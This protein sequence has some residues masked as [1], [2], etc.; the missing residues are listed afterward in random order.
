[1]SVALYRKISNWASLSPNRVR[2]FFLECAPLSYRTLKK[3]GKPAWAV[4]NGYGFRSWCVSTY[5]NKGDLAMRRDLCCRYV[6]F[7]QPKPT[8]VDIR[9]YVNG[10]DPKNEIFSRPIYACQG[11]FFR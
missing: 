5:L 6:R 10:V 7:G 8:Y 11:W 3:G 4:R 1:M 2:Q 9:R